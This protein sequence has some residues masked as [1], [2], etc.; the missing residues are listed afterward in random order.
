M[1]ETI[2]VLGDGTYVFRYDV[3]EY[4]VGFEVFSATC[5]P[6]SSEELAKIASPSDLSYRKR[7]DLNN[8]TDQLNDAERLIEGD[9]RWDGC[10]N[11]LI[12]PDQDTMIHTCSAA[13]A[14]AIG[15]ALHIAYEEAR[16]RLPSADYEVE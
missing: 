14:L 5:G 12:E 10:A 9:I 15:Q 8:F 2:H 4:V 3:K 16:Q 1:N 11:F 6:V 7:K 13:E